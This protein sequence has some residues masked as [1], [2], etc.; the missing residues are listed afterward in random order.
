MDVRKVQGQVAKTINNYGSINASPAD[1]HLSEAE[2]QAKFKRDTGISCPRPIREIFNHAMQCHGFC[3][4]DLRRAW[5]H[6]SVAWDHDRQV[7][8]FMLPWM[9]AAMAWSVLILLSLQC[10]LI[11]LGAYLRPPLYPW[12]H[13]LAMAVIAAVW[14]FSVWLFSA[15]MVP[16][17][18]AKRLRRVVADQAR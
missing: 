11:A 7:P 3:A 9:E 6:K 15:T 2:Q 5:K 18:V 10:L 1:T 14:V 16:R 8:V 4:P 13:A 17:Q 12:S